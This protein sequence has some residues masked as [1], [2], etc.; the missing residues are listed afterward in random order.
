VAI[1]SL[2][3]QFAKDDALR[4]MLL[5][6]ATLTAR[7]RHPNVVPTLDVVCDSDRVL[8]VMEYFEG[9]DLSILERAEVPAPVAAAIV[10]DVLLGLHAAHELCDD[11][12]RPLSVV[13]RDVSPANVLVGVDGVARVLDFG[14]AKAAS[15]RH[16]TQNQTV[17]GK[18]RYM[19]PEHLRGE[20]VDRRSDIYA[21]G[22]VLWEL[23]AG[24]PLFEST[25]DAELAR[26]IVRGKEDPPSR[27]S[28]EE[29]S[30]ALD[31]VVLKAIAVDRGARWATAQEMGKALTDALTAASRADV[32]AR[33]KELGRS[34]LDARARLV[35]GEGK[36]ASAAEPEAAAVAAA[37]TKSI[38]RAAIAPARVPKRVALIGAGALAGAVLV[39]A[40]FIV[41]SRS[42][43]ATSVDPPAS[44][45]AAV[46]APPV[47]SASAPQAPIAP[48][49]VS[50][51]VPTP[52]ALAS[53]RS[54]SGES[55]AGPPPAARPAPPTRRVKPSV[56][57]SVPYSVDA[58]GNRHYNPESVE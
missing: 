29:L 58:K 53:S 32:A 35:R 55:N 33:V 50:P 31:R 6:E 1:K 3:P 28:S 34:E 17:R 2:H 26:K 14:V 45:S 21:V 19:S 16:V 8:L 30:E 13:H 9:I 46:A 40:G 42:A 10:G 54:A 36:R 48:A 5:D 51:S 41:G 49:S 7:I 39:G 25:N 11:K 43:K 18:L 37:L 47:A 52:A 38:S 57:C 27:Y 24:R 22:V 44:A 12:G 23:L 20:A 56:D 15:R 4:A